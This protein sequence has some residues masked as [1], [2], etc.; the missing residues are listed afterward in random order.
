MV[1]V[2]QKQSAANWR[3]GV[4]NW[5][6]RIVM[7]FPSTGIWAFRTAEHFGRFFRRQVLRQIL[8]QFS[9]F[10]WNWNW[11]WNG[12]REC[13]KNLG[14][15]PPPRFF[16]TPS[17]HSNFN[18]NS[19]KNVVYNGR[20]STDISGWLSASKINFNWLKDLK[21]SKSSRIFA[22]IQQV[23]VVSRYCAFLLVF[24]IHLFCAWLE[25]D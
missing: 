13:Q 11:S 17:S 23:V 4:V 8:R 21:R 5:R 1:K 25:V 16:D 6:K 14:G 2:V 3:V 20:S 7:R 9:I 22:S 18:S 24:V 15:L 12:L 19:I 10:E